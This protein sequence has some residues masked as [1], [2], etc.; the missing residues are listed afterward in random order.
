MKVLQFPAH[1][2]AR[3]GKWQTA[4][5]IKISNVVKRDIYR[6]PLEPSY[7][8]WAILWKERS[9]ALKLSF[10]EATGDQGAWPPTYNFNSGDIERYLKTLVSRDGGRSW[11]D[12]GW[13][14]DMDPL[15]EVN[16]DHSIRH[17]FEL[18]DGTLMRH[19]GHTVEG[20]VPVRHS[21]NVYDEAK[22]GRGDFP[23]SMGP[24]REMHPVFA[25]VCTSDDGGKSWKEIY[26]FDKQPPLFITAMH[27]LSDGTILALGAICP[28]AHDET[29]WQG[30][31][32][33][34]KDA[35]RTWTDP[36]VVAP[37]D[38][39][40]NPKGIGA[41]CD[42]VELDDGRV[43]VIWR[44]DAAGSCMRQLTLSRDAT[45]AWQASPAEINPFF[46]HSGYPYMHRAGDGTIFYCCHAS[47]KYSCD[48][49]ATWGE[50][51]PGFSYYGQL[52]E[53][54]PGRILAVTQ[55]N[56]G[57]CSYPWKHDTSML[58]TTFDYARIGVAEQT[59][60]ACVGALA[61]LD[62][63]EHADFHLTAEVR[64]DAACGLAW[65]VSDG[66]FRF[67]ALTIP[68]ND[69]RLPAKERGKEQNAFLAIGRMQDGKTEIVRKIWAGKMTPGQWAELQ[70]TRQGDLLKAAVKLPSLTVVWGAVYTCVRDEGAEPGGL[71]LFT[72]K[73][74][75]AF[76][77]VQFAGA[78]G[79]IRSNWRLYADETGRRIALE[80][81]RAE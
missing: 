19:S 34:S 14:E 37:N 62:V 3:K 11:E 35:G 9:G 74:T 15:R 58:Q 36:V 52:T 48:D 44:T 6:S 54:S 27:P 64:V 32:T 42:F 31:L 33:E 17:V 80:A 53:V 59:D 77:N 60:V 76:R 70:V 5:D 4:G 2:H 61:R 66:R 75:G 46:V 29:T 55:K 73:S 12:T 51:P 50:I 25:S 24:L 68:A 65:Q 78:G 49:G 40:L 1:L 81:G 28:D 23:F 13:R 21:L 45:G 8:S 63:G 67:A 16:S 26:L 43:L 22:E 47:V 7:V 69:A 71:G 57:D 41:E 30:A 10:V 38:D 39:A 56:I 79:E 72:S 18:P 20:G